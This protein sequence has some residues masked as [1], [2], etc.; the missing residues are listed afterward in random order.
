MGFEVRMGTGICILGLAFW[1]EAGI[2]ASRLGFGPQ[3][4]DLGLES[5]I[6][7]S[8][9]GFGPRGKD[10]GLEDRTLASKLG[11]GPR[12]WDLDLGVGGGRR[13][14]AKASDGQR[15]PLPLCLLMK[16]CGG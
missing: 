10:L 4:W 1:L 2:W 9:L 3:G 16:L 8:S 7:A 5:R 15:Y 12:G 13:I 11:F 6:W 14:V